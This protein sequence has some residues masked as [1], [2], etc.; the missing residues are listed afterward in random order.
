MGSTFGVVIATRNRRELVTEAVTSLVIQQRQPDAVVVVDDGSTD[1]TA[2]SLRND[3]PDIA[4]ISQ[5]PLGQSIARNTGIAHLNTDWVCFLDSDDLWHKRK[6]LELQHFITNN[7]AADAVMHP[8]WYFSTTARA[9]PEAHGF[10]I[11]FVAESL[12]QCHKLADSRGLTTHFDNPDC[13]RASYRRL[14][15]GNPHVPS[16]TAVLRETALRSGLFPPGDMEDWRFNRNVAR[17][18]DWHILGQRLAFL[19]VHAGQNTT[20][21]VQ[22]IFLLTAYVDAWWSGRPVPDR[23]PSFAETQALLLKFSPIY[24]ERVRYAL[25]S[26]I[27]NKQMRA[28]LLALLLG[29]TLLPRFRDKAS[30]LLPPRIADWLTRCISQGR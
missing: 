21:T 16:C 30:V 9:T 10:P 23:V 6:L 17:I 1:G 19:R 5:P 18:T 2:A 22:S 24:R 25:W 26:D 28:A 7:P 27:K 13:Q 8:A 29:S 20:T 14:L 3:F 15:E 4:V 12:D 11:D